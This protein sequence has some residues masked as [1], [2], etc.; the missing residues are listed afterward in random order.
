MNKILVTVYALYLEKQYD[1]MIPINLS[2]KD[3]LELIQQALAELSDN[4][5]KNNPQAALY[6]ENGA[7]INMNNIVK[8][9]GLYNGC[10]VILI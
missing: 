10:K 1:I 6:N 4:S 8:F 5:Y 7:I 3:A 2:V 9:S